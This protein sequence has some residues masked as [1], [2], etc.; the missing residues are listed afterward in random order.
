MSLEG[1]LN[2]DKPQGITS[3]DVVNHLRRLSSIRRVGHAGTLDPLATGVLLLCIG[4]ATRLAE[5]LIGRPKSYLAAVRLGQVTDSYDAEGEIV[6]EQE[7]SVSEE[8]IIEALSTF[9]GTIQ[10]KAPAFSAI[11]QQGTPLYKLAREGKRVDAPLR[12]VHIYDLELLA[13]QKPYAHIRVTCSAGTYI[14]S[15]AHDLGQNLGCGG[16]ITALRR[17]AIGDFHVQQAVALDDLEQRN[18]MDYLQPSDSAV[19]HLPRLDLTLDEARHLQLGRRIPRE[20][21]HPDAGLVR[22]YEPDGRFLGIVISRDSGWQPHK[23]F[24]AA[25]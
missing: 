8:E 18:W 11:K 25:T 5:Y 6:S 21:A 24:L 1:I 14:R 19:R 13:W 3:H 22:A 15:L 9:R 16:H 7:V 17:I 12:E 2:I 20:E 4:R 10:Q 23:M